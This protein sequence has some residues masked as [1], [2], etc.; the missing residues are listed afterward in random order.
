MAS[1]MADKKKPAVKSTK[2]KNEKVR[3][4]KK[5]QYK[6]FRIHKKIKPF[7][8]PL[9]SAFK[10]FKQSA[11][12]L[13]SH[14]RLFI[15]IA[16]VYALLTLVFVKG[17]SSNL[18]LSTLKDSVQTYYGGSSSNVVGIAALFGVLVSTGGVSAGTA[19][20]GAYQTI[21]IILTS[22]ATIWALRQT[23]ASKI[24]KTKDSFYK[25]L[26]PLAPFILVLI[27][28][29]LQLLPLGVG[30]WLYNVAITGGIAITALERVLWIL[31]V[32][33]LFTL[34]LY[35]ISSSIFALFIVALPDMQPVQS[36]RSARQ[37]VLHRRWNV[38]RKVVFLPIAMIII[39]AVCMLPFLIWLPAAAEW[40][41]FVL[42]AIGWIFA[43]SYI[44]SLYRELLNE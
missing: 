10:L 26:Y 29:A 24:V 39:A 33:L 36:L 19:D 4:R 12:T 40:V 34:S 11:V 25:G 31:I 43:I 5:P 20:A 8:K 37:L 32:L 44:Y 1:S 30:G 13:F 16:L 2:A 35:M 17:F 23:H 27:V 38:A 28:I 14:K 9:P 41:F 18:D 7:Q 15:G 3:M 42:S 22:L 21:I 6:S